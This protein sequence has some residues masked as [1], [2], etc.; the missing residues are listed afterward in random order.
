MQ[1]AAFEAALL[2][3]FSLFASEP[4]DRPGLLVGDPKAEVEG[5]LCTLD[6]SIEALSLA[7]NRNLNVVLSHHPL[8]LEP[9]K[10]I[11]P[12]TSDSSL[13]GSLVWHAAQRD[14]SLISLHTNL[15]RSEEAKR[16]F[17]RL[18]DLSYLGSATESG[19]GALL[20]APHHT[21][22][23]VARLLTRRL[24]A[25]PRIWGEGSASADPL[26]YLSG[27]LGDLGVEAWEMGARCIVTGEAS[28]H[29]LQELLN[30]ES[31]N[32]A[33]PIVIII[34]H[35]VS[36]RPYAQLLASIAAELLESGNVET[37]DAPLLWHDLPD[38][39]Q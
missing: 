36:E 26:A 7:K 29:R 37:F 17:A 9:P 27:S 16:Y 15:D 38:L 28:Y 11:S 6:P 23:D 3:R 35:D 19:Y 39:E 8:F 31:C 14:L 13:A 21:A 34:G 24:G 1:V 33:K 30:H 12:Y 4:W 32:K 25:R 20:R 5:V 22:D 18:L 2:Q 10:R